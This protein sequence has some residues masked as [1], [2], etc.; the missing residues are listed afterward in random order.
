MIRA[1]LAMVWAVLFLIVSMPVHLIYLL[2]GRFS[3]ARRDRFMQAWVKAGF[4]VVLFLCGVR[5]TVKG[6][7]NIPKDRA[8]VYYAN[9][10][11]IF[12]VIAAYTCLPA[13]TGVLAKQE[14]GRIPLLNI[15]MKD[16]YCLFLDRSSAEKGLATIMQAIDIVKSGVSYMVYPEGTRNR[17]E[18]TLLPFH[19]GSFKIALRT[20][21]LIVPLTIVNTGDIFEPHKPFVKPQH[22]ILDFGGPIETKTIRPADRKK[23]PDEVR[24]IIAETYERDRAEL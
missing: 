19:A 22:V 7:E 11:S 8:C 4:R 15:M 1:I 17:E 23:L 13:P 12:D 10:R 5:V 6:K 16:I 9:H 2:I 24:G 21:A 20:Q 18:G 14:L 3:T